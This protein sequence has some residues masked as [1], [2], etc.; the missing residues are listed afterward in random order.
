M[1]SGV[2]LDV[3]IDRFPVTQE[4]YA[5]IKRRSR[6]WRIW[7]SVLLVFVL[8]AFG[9]HWILRW[10]KLA[11]GTDPG[12][13]RSGREDRFDRVVKTEGGQ[14]KTYR[15]YVG[16]DGEVRLVVEEVEN[17]GEDGKVR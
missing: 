16:P 12:T 3:V 9:L 14:R 11:A 13:A 17:V 6:L 5:R 7:L 8:A 10:Q 4:E 2:T 15:A 1:G